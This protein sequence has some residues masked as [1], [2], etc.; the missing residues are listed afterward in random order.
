M[1]D[2]NSDPS[3]L[4]AGVT[5]GGGGSSSGGSGSGS[6][7]GSSSGGSSSNLPPPPVYDDDDD[8]VSS[9]SWGSYFDDDWFGGIT[10]GGSSGSSDASFFEDPLGWLGDTFLRNDE[11]G[12]GDVSSIELFETPTSSSTR[13]VPSMHLIFSYT[14]TVAAILAIGGA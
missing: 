8:A 3:G 6:S 1:C 9:E 2:L 5:C 12:D 7:S 4:P 11:K 10:G 13:I 14:M